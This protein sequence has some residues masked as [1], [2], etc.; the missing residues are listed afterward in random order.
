MYSDRAKQLLAGAESYDV[1]FK[2]GLDGLKDSDLVAFANSRTGG[3]ILVGV[4]DVDGENGQYG[5]V[6]GCDVSDKS[7]LSILNRA[8]SCV[9]PIELE[10]YIEGV[11]QR[12]FLRIELPS[13]PHK[14]H[15]TGGGRYSI[16][17]NGRTNP[18]L[19][20]QLL[21]LFME[22]EGEAFASRFREVIGPISEQLTRIEKRV[23]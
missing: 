3:T 22:R 2:D 5:K 16:R 14:P 15:C 1:E 17:G 21:G 7:K 9:P 11:G 23:S 20:E 6:I 13:S 8:G 12:P 4:R 18:L 19:P 10:I